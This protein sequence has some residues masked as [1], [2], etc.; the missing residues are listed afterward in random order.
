MMRNR[1]RHLVTYG[2]TI[3]DNSC[4][5]MRT[6]QEQDDVTSLPLLGYSHLTL[7]TGIAYIVALRCQE[8]GELHLASLTVSLHIRIKVK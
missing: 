8:E 2:L 5:N 7:V 4:L 6:L 1:Q 3:H